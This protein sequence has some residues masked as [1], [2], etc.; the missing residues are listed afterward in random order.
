LGKILKTRVQEEV[1]DFP[2]YFSPLPNLTPPPTKVE[3]LLLRQ[4]ANY[5][6]NPI[7]LYYVDLLK[8]I[9]LLPL[10]Q[11][12]DLMTTTTGKSNPLSRE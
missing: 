12:I 5:Q 7:S 11:H 2:G 3:F 10:V 1:L 6:L 9:H 8:L 4:T